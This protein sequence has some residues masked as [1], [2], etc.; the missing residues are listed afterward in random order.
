L[1]AKKRYKYL[2]FLFF[3]T[4]C[5]VS[6]CQS[7]IL[8]F[9]QTPLDQV[10]EA[11]E[12]KSNYIFN[13]DPDLLKEYFYSGELDTDDFNGLMTEILFDTPYTYE[14]DQNTILIYL[15]GQKDYRICGILK[16]ALTQEPL[17]AA[18]I[19]AL[20]TYQGSQSDLLG[21]FDFRINANKNQNIQ[22]SY[23]GYKDITFMAQESQ[24]DA[25]PTYFLEID[26]KLIGQAILIKD[27]ILDGI[28]EGREFGSFGLDF[29]QL[30]KNHSNVEH[31]ILK[32][33]QLL[34]GINSIDDSATNL[35][36]RGSGPDQ[37]LILWEGAP[38]YNA[39]HIFGMISAI[40]P[41]SVDEVNIYKGAYDPRYDNRVGGIVD[42]SLSDSIENTFHGSV[43]TT[44]TEVHSN[45]DIPIIDD[46]ISLLI[47]GR[48]T[49][50]EIYNSPPL[51]NYTKKV[52]Q[53]S[54][55]DDQSQGGQTGAINTE[56]ILDY[57]DL[58][59]KLLYQASEKIAISLGMYSNNQYFNYSFSFPDDPFLASDNIEVNTAAINADI[60]FELNKKWTSKF[61]FYNSSYKNEY[62]NRE[63]EDGIFTGG[64][65]QSNAIEENSFAISN[66]LELSSKF[67][68]KIGYEYNK[69][70]VNLDLGDQSSISQEF[71]SDYN[72]IA[73]F[74]N[75]FSSI[76]Y[77]HE[78]F[79][80]DIGNRTTYY[81]EADLLVHSP[82]IN[83][84]YLINDH[85]KIKA[86]GG[87]YH[88]FISQLNDFETSQVRVDN[89]FWVLNTSED[90]L[91]QKANKI[92]GGFVF[93]Q[94]D[95]LLDVDAYYNSN[96][97]LSS[98]SPVVSQLS[99]NQGVSTGS[100]TSRGVDL[101]LK[102]RWNKFNTWLNYSFRYAE[103]NFPDILDIP[104]LAPNDIRHN[105]SII[106]SYKVKNIQF[107]INT[108]LHSGLPY[109]IPDVIENKEEV[110]PP[111]T[112][113]LEYKN[114]NENRLKPYFRLDFN[115]NY[116]PVFK[117]LRALRPEVS[118]TL[119]NVL[120]YNNVVEQGYYLDFND[121]SL[122]PNL[123]EVNKSLLSRTPLLLIRFYW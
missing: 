19:T 61:S 99:G 9:D 43:G 69:K 52:F 53:Y 87:I 84:Q 79:Q 37:N 48:K 46:H 32:T 65:T 92:A 110:E 35:Q 23:L 4:L 54:I 86:D 96:V 22:I 102:K 27:Y 15:A 93:R 41:F 39:G 103:N 85:L 101:L 118:F 62:E 88:Q 29:D 77:T 97:G 28:F 38:I 26:E 49:I 63:T 115:I 25:C 119:I 108:N 111:F 106:G 66:N 109:S 6:F 5:S 72:E 74:H 17:V 30:S 12:Q 121:Q 10:I 105:V 42:I 107:S 21:Y 75:L 36:I 100:S 33:A 47:S 94:N 122:V 117:K 78:K 13:H 95:W 68:A 34:P 83:F 57:N 16:D 40:N 67:L 104:F 44:L 50:N 81:I 51:Q 56:Q 116:R 3:A 31:D 112:Y 76:E 7:S 80:I 123:E 120:N 60:N 113:F 64:Y 24:Q 82:R 58:T 45:L 59:A 91:S 55:I 1:K 90:Q 8:N 70:E 89:P 18:N 14:L 98:F 114:Y 11:L 2:L 71:I 73:G 20:N